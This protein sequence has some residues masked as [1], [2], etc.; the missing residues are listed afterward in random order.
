MFR[1]TLRKSSP[2]PLELFGVTPDRVASLA[3]VEVAKLPVRHGNRS[4]PLG[5]FFDVTTGTRTNADLHFAGDT[6]NVHGIGAGLTAGSVYVEND[7]GRHT[8]AGMAGG[9]LVIDGDA[10]DWLGAEMTGGSIEVRGPVGNCAGAAYRGSRR[11][12]RGGTMI[13]R[14]GAGDELGLLMR[15][16]L[17][18]VEGPVGEF[19]G[20]SMIAGSLFLFGAVGGRLGAGMKRGTI[21]AGGSEPPLGPGFRFACDYTPSFLTLYLRHL[22]QYEIR[23]PQGASSS[24]VR[25]YRGDL[26]AGGRGE[27][28]VFS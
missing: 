17:I 4:E 22:E 23:P 26:V 19:A 1:L 2:V 27:V 24:R 28:L 18:A 11:G 14:G 8:G 5:E 15:R 16:G 13:L 3:A 6:R 12:L 25:C 21:V 7:A 20:A 10:G 9:S